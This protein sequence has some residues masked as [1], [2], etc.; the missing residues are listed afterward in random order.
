MEWGGAE[1]GGGDRSE[2][3][4]ERR[5]VGTEPQTVDGEVSGVLIPGASADFPPD[6]LHCVTQRDDGRMGGGGGAC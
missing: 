2:P 6:R 4:D 3:A 1:G 5:R